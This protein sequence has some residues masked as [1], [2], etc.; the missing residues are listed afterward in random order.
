[1]FLCNIDTIITINII[2]IFEYGIKSRA[3]EILTSS[4]KQNS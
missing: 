4:W 2:V 3:V 1:M